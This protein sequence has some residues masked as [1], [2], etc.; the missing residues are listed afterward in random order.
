MDLE[1]PAPFDA[2]DRVA[3]IDKIVGTRAERS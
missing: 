2:I 3:V 1:K